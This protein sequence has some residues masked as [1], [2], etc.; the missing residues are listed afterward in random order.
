MATTGKKILRICVYCASSQGCDPKY[1]RAASRLGA[2]LA[3]A[4]VT[5]VY[6]GGRTGSMGALADGALASGG[7]VIGVL[8]RFMDDIEWGHQGLSELVLVNDMHERKRLMIQEVDAVVA[9]PGACGTWEE[10][11]EAMSWKRLG[12]YTGPIV[13]VNTDDYYGPMFTM[14]E[15]SIEYRFM[16]ERHRQMWSVVREPEEVLDAIRSAPGWSER[17]RSFAVTQNS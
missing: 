16:N 6:G 13:I 15:R 10:L 12:L 8:P 5:V 17:N 7:R 4:G 11:F 3:K 2:I 9:L 1:H 14:L